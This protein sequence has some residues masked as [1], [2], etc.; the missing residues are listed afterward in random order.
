MWFEFQPDL[1][2][3][4]IPSNDIPIQVYLDHFIRKSDKMYQSV[5]N[6]AENVDDKH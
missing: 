4:V 6:K 1:I 3:L 5:H 2:N